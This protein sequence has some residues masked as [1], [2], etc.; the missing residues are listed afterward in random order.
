MALS[1]II[2]VFMNQLL[3]TVIYARLLYHLLNF[4]FSSEAWTASLYLFTGPFFG[5]LISGLCVLF[6][7]YLL[8][9]WFHKTPL[10][11][12][13]KQYRQ[14]KLEKNKLANSDQRDEEYSR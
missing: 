11:K 3:A 8:S 2:I 6:S 5:N 10:L 4:F 7:F 13:L 9:G 12:F 14:E 1:V